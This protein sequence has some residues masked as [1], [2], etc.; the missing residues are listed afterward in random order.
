MGMVDLFKHIG[1]K[2]EKKDA[3]PRG[4]TRN[5]EGRKGSN[6]EMKF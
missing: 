5:V 3:T 2:K 4:E 6:S 1:T